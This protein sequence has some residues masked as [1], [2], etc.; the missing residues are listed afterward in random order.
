MHAHRRTHRNT[1]PT[2]LPQPRESIPPQ[3]TEHSRP[4]HRPGV[5][6]P[7]RGFL[8]R[9]VG[10]HYCPIHNPETQVEPCAP[11]A[12][13]ALHAP[14]LPHSAE[15]SPAASSTQSHGPARSHSLLL[16]SWSRSAAS[17]RDASA[18][19][20]AIPLHSPHESAQRSAKFPRPP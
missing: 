13:L 15:P 5:P 11:P 19:T 20:P 16:S 4:G 7:S 12:R 2:P 10:D 3:P 17:S 6:H 8:A 18:P 9:R 1:V 14:V